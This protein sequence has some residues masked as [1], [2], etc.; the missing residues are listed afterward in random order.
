MI[1]ASASAEIRKLVASLTGDAVS[2]DAALARLAVIGARAVPHLTAA[3]GGTAD[4]RARAA[5]L[6]ALEPI[7]DPRALPIARDGLTH[8]GDL[9][10]AAAA[11]LG[12]LLKSSYGATGA[13]ALDSLM[14]AALDQRV[15][16]RVRL[17]AAEALRATDVDLRGKLAAEAGDDSGNGTGEAAAIWKDA[18]DGRMPDDPA[19]LRRALDARAG[20]APLNDLR[21]LIDR[22]RT[23]ETSARSDSDAWRA[24]RGAIHQ[25]LALR[26]SRVA[27]YD[28]RETIEA[29]AAPLPASFVAAV[30]ALGDESCLQAI[31]AAFAKAP[32]EQERWRHQL[33]AAF[34]AIAA[35]ERITARHA[36]MKRISARWPDAAS[37]LSRTRPPRP[38]A[39]R[40]SRTYR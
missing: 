14:T 15:E 13:D 35:R 8:G 29:A 33:G 7:G 30:Q 9:A 3:Y 27:L 19:V 39:S 18:L 23:C 40:T 6:R 20:T 26:G 37:T 4:R 38:T 25:A 24:V 31:A 5:I 1:K 11:V 22:I 32:S 16:R 21:N 10:V 2:R 28:L 17:A 36:V 12:G 34:T